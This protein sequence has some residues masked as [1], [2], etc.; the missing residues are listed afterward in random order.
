MDLTQCGI[1][2]PGNASATGVPSSTT[3]SSYLCPVSGQPHDHAGVM[4]DAV[5]SD[6]HRAI[7]GVPT[8]TRTYMFLVPDRESCW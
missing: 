6:Q 5:V 1:L 8:F 2:F 4:Q 7:P 3:L